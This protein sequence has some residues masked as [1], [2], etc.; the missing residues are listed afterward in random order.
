MNQKE[1]SCPNCKKEILVA[2]KK[3][4][5]DLGKSAGIVLKNIKLVFLN[6]DGEMMIKCKDCKV[7]SSIP[8]NFKSED[9]QISVK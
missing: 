1:F 4:P 9:S 3:D 6:D 2:A 7:I 8:L 5:K